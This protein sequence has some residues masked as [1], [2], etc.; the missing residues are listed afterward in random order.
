MRTLIATLI[1]LM[2]FAAT[3]VVARDLEDGVAA[4]KAG[5]YQKAF[6]LFERLAEQGDV[7]SQYNLGVIYN[8]GYAV[9]DDYARGYAW[10]SI[11]AARGN[12]G[13]KKFKEMLAKFTTPAQI[14]E[15]Q[16][17]SCELWKNT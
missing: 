7:N 1:A 2:L 3:P 5:D 9:P 15:V 4:F 13:G 8:N 10:V 17:L 12:A 16:K 14:A 6:R 11:A